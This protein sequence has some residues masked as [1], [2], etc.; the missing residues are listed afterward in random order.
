MIILLTVWLAASVLLAVALQRDLERAAA[1]ARAR[2][3][4]ARFQRLTAEFAVVRAALV[5]AT[6]AAARFNEAFRPDP[7]LV[8]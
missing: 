8:P 1:R 3:R 4:I 5:E 6:E 7:E 2:A